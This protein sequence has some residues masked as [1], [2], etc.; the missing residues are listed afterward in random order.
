MYC[1]YYQAQVL[2]EKAWFFAGI[3]RSF[4][5]LAFD[6]TF[7]TA[8]SIFECFVPQELEPCFLNLMHYF[9]QEGVVLN[10]QELPNR[11]NV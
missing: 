10:V 8:N 7:D 4:E 3:L 5:H 1:K 9:L 2:K 6:R 11:L